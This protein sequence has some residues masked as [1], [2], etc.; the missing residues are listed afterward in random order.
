MTRNTLLGLAI[1]FVTIWHQ[2]YYAVLKNILRLSFETDKSLTYNLFVR[3]MDLIAVTF[4][5]QYSDKRIYRFRYSPFE[6]RSTLFNKENH[7][8]C[9]YNQKLSLITDISSIKQPISDQE[10]YSAPRYF[11][12]DDVIDSSI[13]IKLFQRANIFFIAYSISRGATSLYP[14][15]PLDADEYCKKCMWNLY[16]STTRLKKFIFTW[17]F[18]P[19]RKNSNRQE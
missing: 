8:L 4:D 11:I 7:Y 16:F 10:F 19:Y 2:D 12:F 6:F 17:P 5:I 18:R 13:G 1:N 15:V 14:G 3:S 9:G